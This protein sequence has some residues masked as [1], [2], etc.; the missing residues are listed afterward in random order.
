MAPTTVRSLRQLS[1]PRSNSYFHEAQE[2]AP[3]TWWK[4]MPE[5]EISPLPSSFR[6]S[7]KEEVEGA[8]VVVGFWPLGDRDT[9]KNL[10]DHEGCRFHLIHLIL[11]DHLANRTVTTTRHVVRDN[12]RSELLSSLTSNLCQPAW[13]PK[14]THHSTNC[15][16]DVTCS[17]DRGLIYRRRSRRPRLSSSTLS[18]KSRYLP[19]L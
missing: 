4:I 18:Y 15:S 2:D 6:V 11:P 14:I 5:D 12:C 1:T 19:L 16:W 7:E 17:C 9:W 3:A 8:F 13:S 10:T